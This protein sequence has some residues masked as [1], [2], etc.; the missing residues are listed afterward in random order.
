MSGVDLHVHT[1]AS[2]GTQ[3]PDE[4]VSMAAARGIH[5][6]AITDHDT[7]S[8]VA[9]ALYRG[10]QEKIRVLPGVEISTESEAGRA[11][12]LGYLLDQHHPALKQS[13]S[14]F[15]RARLV[16]SRAILRRLNELGLGLSWDQV[17]ELAGDGS[18]GRPHIARALNAAGYVQSVEEAFQRYLGHDRP[19]YVPRPKMTPQRGIE[20]ILE[21]GGVP[22]LAH[23][24]GISHLIPRL[25]KAGLQG[26][27]VHYAG[28]NKCQEIQLQ[29]IS[30]QHELV[31]TGG[32]DFHTLQGEPE[33]QLGSVLVP[34]RCVTSLK[35]RWRQLSARRQGE[36]AKRN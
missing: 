8:G 3:R 29:R 26:V 33:N 16:R 25:A 12:I 34:I 13:L 2:D 24:W 32:S 23:P 30:K 4:I 14:R 28:Y 22:V 36:V 15:Q 21:A 11:H 20:L 10:Q 9:A 31:A 19:A 17:Q 1:T 35:R 6:L 7:V 5:T 27:E 18:I